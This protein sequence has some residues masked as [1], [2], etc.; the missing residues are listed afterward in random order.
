MISLLHK[1][2]D[3]DI[4]YVALRLAQRLKN[5]YFTCAIAKLVPKLCAIDQNN[6]D[7]FSDIEVLLMVQ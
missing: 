5:V 3:V 7:L 6:C 4:A 2:L 1:A